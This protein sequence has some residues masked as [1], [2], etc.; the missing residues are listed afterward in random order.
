MLAPK[1]LACRVQAQPSIRQATAALPKTWLGKALRDER[2]W[3][4]D[5]NLPDA[6]ILIL[7]LIRLASRQVPPCSFQAAFDCNFPADLRTLTCARCFFG[8]SRKTS[9]RG[10]ERH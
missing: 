5:A 10:A 1:T 9:R 8:S 4:C 7:I 2:R 3:W 6:L